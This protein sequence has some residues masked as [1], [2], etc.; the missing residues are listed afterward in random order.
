MHYK[1]I[2]GWCDFE[3]IYNYAIERFADNSVFVEIGTWL[4]QSTCFMCELL[5]AKKR[6][7]RFFGIDTFLGEKNADLQQKLVEEEGG[8]IYR[9]FLHNMKDADILGYVTPIAMK[10]ADACKLFKDG[11]VDFIFLDAE[12]LYD[13]VKQDLENWYPKLSK[14][15][16]F[17]GHDYNGEVMQAVD[18]FFKNKH[19]VTRSASSFLIL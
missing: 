5:K 15:G 8:S 17:A 1:N 16:L 19:I 3:N 6:N 9:K 18:E 2:E 10:S 11:S 14:G 13:N 7:I 12:H 4:G